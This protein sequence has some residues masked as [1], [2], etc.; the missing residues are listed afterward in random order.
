MLAKNRSLGRQ[1]SRLEEKLSE[2]EPPGNEQPS[3]KAPPGK[4]D[5]G[6]K[7]GKEPPVSP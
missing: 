6:G 2:R 3:G 5:A 7:K 4:K 1:I